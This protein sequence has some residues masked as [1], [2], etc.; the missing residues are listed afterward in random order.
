VASATV[1]IL[2]GSSRGS[3]FHFLKPDIIVT[4]HHVVDGAS[5]VTA[6]TDGDQEMDLEQLSFSPADEDDYAI[7]RVIDG[8]PKGQA[9]LMPAEDTTVPDRGTP[10]WF[11]GF[12]HGIDDLLVQAASVAGPGHEDAFYIDGSV[13]GGNSGGPVVTAEGKL[14]G[15]VTQRRFIGGDDLESMAGEAQALANYCEQLAQQSGSAAIMGIDFGQFA[16]L[17]GR[18]NSLLARSLFDNANVG[19]GIAFCPQQLLDECER[20]DLS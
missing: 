7:F 6:V 16:G 12:P 18:S 4:N 19:L 11:S 15:I 2:A 1:Q 13:N 3:G 8:L 10:V 17:V 14:A 5:A 9:A 20:L